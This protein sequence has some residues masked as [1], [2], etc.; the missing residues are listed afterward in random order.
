MDTI[1]LYLHSVR[2]LLK[3]HLQYPSSFILQTV[4]QIIMEAGELMAVLLLISR[5][6]SMKE[7]SGGNLLVFFGV[8]SI[9]F[10]LTEFFGRGITGSFAS[11]IRNG[12]LD[13][14]L[15]RPRGVITQVLCADLD[16]RRIGCLAVGTV[17]MIL[18]CRQSDVQWT[19]LK[20]IALLEAIGFGVLLILELF[21]IEAVFSIYS[22]KSLEMVNALTYGGRSACE[23]PM[24]VFP[25][26]IQLIFSIIAPFSLTLHV[27]TAYILDKP[28][29]SWPDWAAFVCPLAGA[30]L[31]GI[32]RLIFGKALQHYRSTG[33]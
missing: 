25:R 2:M 9:A 21:L 30:C 3:S 17:A 23:Y 26:P 28:L 19:V 16:P 18:G 24:D 11:L 27:P 1:R 20:V 6:Q 22:V 13:A 4:A 7:W 5:F 31:F 29:F 15:L 8:M 14:I 10:Y 33:S 32:M 12:T